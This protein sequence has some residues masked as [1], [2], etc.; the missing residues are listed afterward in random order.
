M[1]TISLK[2][3][4]L[5][6]LVLGVQLGANLITSDTVFSYYSQFLKDSYPTVTEKPILPVTIERIDRPS[7]MKIASGGNT[8]KVFVSKEDDTVIQLQGDRFL[9][10]WRKGKG[11]KDYPHFDHVYSQFKQQLGYLFN[12]NAQLSTS[13]NQYEITYVDH[14]ESSVVSP[15]RYNLNEIFSFISL[16]NPVRSMDL[17][18]S[19]PEVEIN[20]NLSIV[21][22]SGVRSSDKKPL[23]VL[24]TTCRGFRPDLEIDPWF[25]KARAILVEFFSQAT[26][27]EL[28]SKWEKT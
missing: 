8:R 5:V 20:G 27:K 7:Q 22:R 2:K 13:I 21:V 3:P 16:S 28:Q 26:T 24:E 11:N 4:P 1:T 15:Q 23:M 19:I 9:F 17:N 18:L 12:I 10:N 6:E 25:S 14:I